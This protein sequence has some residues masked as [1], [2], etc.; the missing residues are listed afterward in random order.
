M[1]V[2]ELANFVVSRIANNEQDTRQLKDTIRHHLTYNARKLM[3]GADGKIEFG[4]FIAWARLQPD[5]G[6]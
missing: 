1:T 5:G 3:R 2:N 6:H 4:R